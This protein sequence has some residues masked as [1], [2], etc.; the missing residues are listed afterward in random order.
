MDEDFEEYAETFEKSNMILST[1][2]S[3]TPI[4]M[5]QMSNAYK[6]ISDSTDVFAPVLC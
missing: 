3:G 5:I 2:M 4:V 1:H 6:S